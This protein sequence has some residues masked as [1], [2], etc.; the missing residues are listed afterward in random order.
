MSKSITR[1]C[2]L[3]QSAAAAF[4]GTF[5]TVASCNQPTTGPVMGPVPTGRRHPNIRKAVK[6]HMVKE[7]LSLED[8]FKLLKD[9]GFDGV[10]IDTGDI[11][12][13][14]VVKARE[15]TG[16][17]VHGVVD[18]GCWEYPLTDPDPEVR[19]KGMDILKTAANDAA[20][21]GGSSVLVVPGKVT[22]KVSYADAYTRSQEAMKEA[23]F[24]GYK[25]G[26]KIL[27]E[28]VWNNFLLSPLEMARYIDELDS[29][30]VGAYLDTGNMMPWGWPEDWIRILGKR[31]V[32]LDIK[33]FS[34]SKCNQEGLRKGFNVKLLEGD[35]NWPA[36]MTALRE[37][38]YKG[39]A[40][41]EM[42]GGD[43]RRLKEIA[44]RMDR[45]LTS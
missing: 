40:T 42:P 43:R 19:A 2:F 33:E 25:F 45:A 6:Y 32:K 7:N 29:Q 39:W 23:M 11:D 9:L 1:R 34:R 15:K 44:M 37:V 18:W 5:V 17:E 28:N 26:L 8:K 27:I 4:S 3:E 21:Y 31:I 36:I 13:R 24:Y 30:Y 41:A 10:E 12:R 38:N 14:A 20:Y 35:N 22:Q 16:L